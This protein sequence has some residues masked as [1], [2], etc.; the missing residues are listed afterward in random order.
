MCGIVGIVSRKPD[1]SNEKR[2]RN[3]LALV[4]H[5]GPDDRGLSVSKRA[6]LGHARLSI[7]DLATGKQPIENENG[8]IQLV[9]NGEIFNFHALRRDLTKKGHVFRTQT[10][11]EVIVHAYEEYG[12]DC[13]N[14]FNGQFAFAI[15]DNR[16]GRLF[17]AR[18][19][20]GVIPLYYRLEPDRLIFSSEIKSILSAMSSAPDIDN[21]A[22]NRYLAIGYTWGRQ[23]MYAGIHKLEPGA[24]ALYENGQFSLHCYWDLYSKV[25]AAPVSSFSHASDAFDVLLRD[26]V[27]LRLISDVPLG[28]FLSGGLDSSTLVALG[29]EVADRQLDTFSVSFGDSSYD[30][31]NFAQKVALRYNTN[32]HIL[33]GE[34]GAEDIIENVLWHLD[35]PIA[36][37]ATIPTYLL[38]RLTK[39]HVTVALSGDGSDELF[40]GYNK[41]IA[42]LLQDRYVKKLPQPVQSLLMRYIRKRMPFR[43]DFYQK[44]LTMPQRYY[45]LLSAFTPAERK[46]LLIGSS[47]VYDCEAE[48]ISSIPSGLT[49]LQQVQ[50][51]DIRNWLANDILLK[52]DKMSMAA[53]L[54]TRVPFLDHR[55]IELALNCTDDLKIKRFMG[56]YLI[57]RTYRN[58]LPFSVVYRKKQGFNYPLE[59]VFS[60]KKIG[61]YFHDSS[62]YSMLSREKVS[63][64]VKDRNTNAFVRRQFRNLFFLFIWNKIFIERQSCRSGLN[65]AT[66]VAGI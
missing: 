10:D 30:E 35:E 47:A 55:V 57:K 60:E 52:T 32:H 49:P 41:F 39:Q 66:G 17:I 5:R 36:D 6:V 18:D 4:R 64:I 42:L 51:I 3:M 20:I 23:T 8:D 61:R 62:L 15:W 16:H 9:F 50:M 28:V 2:V 33:R 40:G 25:N 34:T 58:K 44:N 46:Q 27:K 21:E 11:S 13:L 38:A 1:A 31:S 45:S 29:S 54:E 53:S 56:K 43:D 48:A 26:S 65:P 14:H 63:A 12:Y 7:I 22:L 19:R 59:D 37:Q 24:Y